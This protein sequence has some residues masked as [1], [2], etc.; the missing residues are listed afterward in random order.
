MKIFSVGTTL[1]ITDVNE[2]SATTAPAL[3][4]N[5]RAAL[6][7]DT[8]AVEIELSDTKFLD[9]SGLR[10][11]ISIQKTMATRQGSIC[12]V[13]PTSTVV[14]VLELTRLHRV[15]EVVRR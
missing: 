13:N 14:Q 4:D 11:L 12:V 6:K 8:T 10:A 1:R 3:R 2:L 5:F 15:I 7:P 9:S